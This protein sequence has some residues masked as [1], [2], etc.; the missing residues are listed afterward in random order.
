MEKG[1]ARGLKKETGGELKKV[2]G[3][4]LNRRTGKA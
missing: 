1:M 4:G 2:M 3:E